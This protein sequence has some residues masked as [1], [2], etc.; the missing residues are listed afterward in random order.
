MYTSPL[1]PADEGGSHAHTQS[2]LLLPDIWVNILLGGGASPFASVIPR[3]LLRV[4]A[5]AKN[6]ERSHDNG[7]EV[8]GLRPGDESDQDLGSA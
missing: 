7:L 5:L 3:Q 1:A 8:Y 6:L 4:C 2:A